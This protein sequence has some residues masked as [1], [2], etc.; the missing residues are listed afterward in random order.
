MV[1]TTLKVPRGVEVRTVVRS[2]ACST[3]SLGTL[4]FNA[5]CA[6]VRSQAVQDVDR[7][8]VA[9]HVLSPAGEVLDVFL[10]LRV[11]QRA[12]CPSPK[13]ILVCRRG[14]GPFSP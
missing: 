13:R 3:T 12:T 14:P 8:P 2:V 5:P 11:R 6:D 10:A 7:Q 4:A 1:A 9:K